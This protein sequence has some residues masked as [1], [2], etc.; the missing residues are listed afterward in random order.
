MSSCITC[1]K[2][3]DKFDSQYVNKLYNMVRLQTDAPF[4]CFTDNP[5]DINPDVIVVDID[6]SEYKSWDNWWAAWWR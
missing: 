6:V 4:Y 2:I 1:I 5:T 3:G